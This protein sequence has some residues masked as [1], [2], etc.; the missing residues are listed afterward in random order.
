M[1]PRDYLAIPVLA[2]SLAYAM[3]EMFHWRGGLDRK[4]GQAPG[5]Y[6][7]I[8]V[9]LVAGVLLDTLG[10]S[11]IQALLYRVILYGL[12]APVMIDLVLHLA[13]NKAVMGSYAN[14][15]TSNLL[16]AMTLVLRSTAAIL[17][18]YLQFFA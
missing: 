10:V 18:L 1:Y 8:F 4:F 16:G 7:T 11:P 9:S 15:R 5:F 6:A 14:G 17:L 2:G 13:N 12:T 3:A